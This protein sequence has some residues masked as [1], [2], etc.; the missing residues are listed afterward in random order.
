[1]KFRVRVFS[2]P[3]WEDIKHTVAIHRSV[4]AAALGSVIAEYLEG[5]VAVR[6]VVED[7]ALW[8]AVESELD[9]E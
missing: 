5:D 1:M 3:T 8:T 9:D 7:E 4:T 6:V 2:H